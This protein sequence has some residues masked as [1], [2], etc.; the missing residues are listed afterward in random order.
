MDSKGSG[1]G[2]E[3]GALGGIIIASIWLVAITLVVL[4]FGTIS[5]EEIF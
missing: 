4:I 1:P 2:I 5:L 3:V